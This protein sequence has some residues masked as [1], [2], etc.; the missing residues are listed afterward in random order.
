MQLTAGLFGNTTRE[1]VLL[2][3]ENYGDGNATEIARTFEVALTPV[4]N[5]LRILERAGV[6]VSQL[7]GKTRVFVWNPRYPYLRELR[8][9]LQKVL[10]FVPEEEDEKYFLQRRRPRRSGKPY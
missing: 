2:F 10:T 8:S 3:L 1:K 9:L 4:Q 5:Q 7:K 6:V